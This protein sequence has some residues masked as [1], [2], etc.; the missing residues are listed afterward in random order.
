MLFFRSKTQNILKDGD[1]TAE[2][3]ALANDLNVKSTCDDIT[4]VAEI[5]IFE[6]PNP[7]FNDQSIEN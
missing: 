6:Q 5:L 2:I 7:N 4:E 3:E 1:I